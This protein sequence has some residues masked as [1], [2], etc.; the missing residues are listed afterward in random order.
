MPLCVQVYGSAPPPGAGLAVRVLTGNSIVRMVSSFSRLYV[1]MGSALVPSLQ[2]S[3]DTRTH[4]HVLA[5]DHP[6]PAPPPLPPS[7]STQASPRLE[8]WQ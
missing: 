3:S 2:R 7:P 5:E 1:S 4:A 6:R 8:Q